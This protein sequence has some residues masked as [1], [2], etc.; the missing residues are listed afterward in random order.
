M[1]RYVIYRPLGA[2]RRWVVLCPDGSILIHPTW[3]EARDAMLV[4]AREAWLDDL[5]DQSPIAVSY[6][7]NLASM[8]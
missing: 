8:A 2:V 7:E 1:S 3:V 4:A 5:F 6:R